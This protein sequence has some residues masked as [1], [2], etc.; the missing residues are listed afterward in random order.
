MRDL[1][2]R[3]NNLTGT[4]QQ[5][6]S[7]GSTLWIDPQ[8]V[9]KQTEELCKYPDD[10]NTCIKLAY[11]LAKLA[12]NITDIKDKNNDWSW[13]NSPDK[14]QK[15]YDKLAIYIIAYICL[16]SVFITGGNEENRH[17]EIISNK[18]VK[19]PFCIVPILKYILAL[20]NLSPILKHLK[21]GTCKKS[22]QYY[23]EKARKEIWKTL[24]E[25]ADMPPS[26]NKEGKIFAIHK[27]LA[28]LEKLTDN[29]RMADLHLNELEKFKVP[30]T[31]L[32]ERY[33]SLYDKGRFEYM[34]SNITKASIYLLKAD[35]LL[36]NNPSI[37][38]KDR[39]AAE[40][41]FMIG[42]I[43]FLDYNGDP[44]LKEEGE[45]Y[46]NICGVKGLLFLGD[47]Y[48][49]EE[50]TFAKAE[51]Y[52]RKILSHSNCD[53][54]LKNS[55]N[56]KLG[57]LYFKTE[58]YENAIP[59]LEPVVTIDYR[60]KSVIEGVEKLRLMRMFFLCESYMNTKQ[61]AKAREILLQNLEYPLNSKII[62]RIQYNIAE[63]YID[64]NNSFENSVEAIKWLKLAIQGKCDDQPLYNAFMYL[65]IL[66]CNLNEFEDAKQY[67]KKFQNIIT[68]HR[69]NGRIKSS[70]EPKFSEIY[71][72]LK[73]HF[74]SSIISK[75]F[76]VKKKNDSRLAEPLEE[77]SISEQKAENQQETPH[78][79]IKQ[80]MPKDSSVFIS[81]LPSSNL[82]L[83]VAENS[84]SIEIIE[85]YNQGDIIAKNE[86]LDITAG[87][88]QT[89]RLKAARKLT[90]VSTTQ[91]KSNIKQIIDLLISNIPEKINYLCNFGKVYPIASL[92]NC[93]IFLP[94]SLVE[95]SIINYERE[96]LFQTARKHGD[97]GIKQIKNK[98]HE[99][100]INDKVQKSPV[101]EVKIGGSDHRIIL[102]REGNL[103]IPRYA[104][105]KT[106]DSSSNPLHMVKREWTYPDAELE[107]IINYLRSGNTKYLE[108]SQSR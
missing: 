40:L 70:E 41:Q 94:S 72:F 61:Q 84:N 18:I 78:F 58:K 81:P 101:A 25:Y 30:A 96:E 108:N 49:E 79:E 46:L 85:C 82:A 54:E 51:E 47:Y 50:E 53:E 57:E 44:K 23:I 86:S 3:N 62:S 33:S 27:L 22:L 60:N 10:F 34:A 105:P 65:I 87:T 77:V 11:S 89:T 74:L 38:D 73:G 104:G 42:T 6:K 102:L 55:A 75:D 56:A 107:K 91:E 7:S 83:E 103:F 98:Q 19:D 2:I 43:K 13:F 31:I 12:S 32:S 66:C 8:E 28:R 16:K 71:Q 4:N 37:V 1:L 67:L 100:T 92:P 106:K 5:T 20:D 48:S 99:L 90:P 76:T 39:P 14:D 93:Y 26:A 36:K 68:S 63:S 29:P 95:S 9:F 24:K 21:A 45:V 17:A 64:E 35:E 69:K 52:L 15:S 88:K 80:P 59:L 97:Q